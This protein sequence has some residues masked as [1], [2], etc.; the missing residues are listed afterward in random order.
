MN[1]IY[2]LKELKKIVNNLKRQGNRIVFTNG[3]FDVFHLGHLTL[4]N[5]CKKYGDILVVGLNS[6]SSV[7]RLKGEDRPIN[8]EANRVKFL[9]LLDCVD[10]IIVFNEDTPLNLIKELM[11]DILIKGK[12]Y[13]QDNV[14]GADI[15]KANGGEVY[16]LDFGIEI[17][18]TKII[19]KTLNAFDQR[20]KLNEKIREDNYLNEQIKNA[21]ELI[22]TSI[23]KNKKIFVC[24]NGGSA[25]EANHF[26]A[27]LVGSFNKNKKALPCISLCSDSTLLTA[28]TNDFKHEELFVQQLKA[29]KQ[30]GD[31]LICFTT[32]GKS[33]NIVSVLKYAHKNHLNSIAFC[34]NYL[35][36]VLPYTNICISVPTSKTE[37]IQEAHLSYIHIIVSGVKCE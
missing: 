7:K 18:S 21:T 6:D 8:C 15:V 5:E 29:L 35:D 22:K 10:Y 14:V 11:P 34:G 27:E 3:C 23:N 25:S 24:G 13:N 37:M 17:S 16:C 33:S 12:N 28:L 20:K 30:D 31:L 36:D 2:K 1:K 26:M 9:E 32:S 19:D 4:L